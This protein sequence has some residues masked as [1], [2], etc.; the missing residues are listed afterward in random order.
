MRF[1]QY[2]TKS[3]MCIKCDNH[4]SACGIGLCNVCIYNFNNS[5]AFKLFTTLWETD[6]DNVEM[7]EKIVD[8]WV[9]G[10]LI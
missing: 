8:M 2:P 6:D 7:C 5:V 3:Y 1:K 4:P 9:S 10:D